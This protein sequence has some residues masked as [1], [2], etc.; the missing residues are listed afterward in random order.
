VGPVPNCEQT[1]ARRVKPVADRL[2]SGVLLVVLSPLLGA[3][4]AAVRMSL[5]SPIIYRQTRV[6]LGGERFS[7]LKFRTMTPDRRLA[8]LPFVGAD[9]RTSWEAT[10]DARHTPL[11]S[12][13]R[14]ASLDELPQL[15]NVARGEMSLIGPRPEVPAAVATY[16]DKAAE[17]HSVRPGVT[18]LWQVTARGDMPMEQAVDIDLEYV[19]RISARL[20][21]WIL[22]RTIPELV[23]AAREPRPSPHDPRLA[24]RRGIVDGFV[25]RPHESYG[26][27]GWALR[28]GMRN[29][30]W[31]RAQGVSRLVEE[32]DVRPV[33]NAVAAARRAQWRRAHGVTPGQAT[34]ALVGGVPRSG[35]NMFVRGLA[36]LPEVEAYNEGDRAAFH[37]YRM[38]PAPVLR[39]LVARSRHRLVV[40][41]PLLDSDRLPALLD[42]LGTPVPPRCVWVY[43]DVDGRVRSALAKFGPNA[44]E[45]MRAIASGDGA[46]LWQAQGLSAQSLELIRSVDWANASAQDGAALLW[47]VKNRMFFEHGLDRR[48]DVLP[49]SYG[50]L[51]EDPEGTMRHVCRFLGVDWRRA[52]SAHIDRRSTG[53]TLQVELDPMI[54]ELCEG[55]LAEL[56]TAAEVL[57]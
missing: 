17:R 20:D 42:G 56:D 27:A 30:Q 51:V 54:R 5:G 24:E 21:A 14:R 16:A 15:W 46:E 28:L 33:R 3:V 35:T 25:N 6:G 55:M 41:K 29:A 26:R 2:G 50:R 10:N 45:A 1:Y 57:A 34:A 43:R 9:R 4:A 18:G 12:V 47:Y 13:L 38:R 53:A 44:L 7:M 23:R 48:E 11:G 49:V 32:H 40:I 19:R 22:L 52:A 39:E 36:A 37:R 8:D 31:A